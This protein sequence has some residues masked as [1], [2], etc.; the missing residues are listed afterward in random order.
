[1]ETL[2]KTGIKNCS[3]TFVYIIFLNDILNIFL[4][5]KTGDR[6]AIEVEHWH[7]A[8]S[9]EYKTLLRNKYQLKTTIQSFKQRQ[10]KRIELNWIII[11]IPEIRKVGQD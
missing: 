3:V 8:T 2:R 11:I 10:M 5:F 4:S 6:L 9:N 1:M 7:L